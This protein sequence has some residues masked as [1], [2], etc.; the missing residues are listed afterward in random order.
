MVPQHPNLC[1]IK[2]HTPH[3]HLCNTCAP[4][5]TVSVTATKQH[6][7][8][9][10]LTMESLSTNMPSLL[11]LSPIPWL[12]VHLHCI[13]LTPCL[14][15]MV[16]QIV[17]THW[18]FTHANLTT[19]KWFTGQMVLQHPNS[20][21]SSLTTHTTGHWSV[22]KEICGVFGVYWQHRVVHSVNSYVLSVLW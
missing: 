16:L 4:Q 17:A 1:H 18:T 8:Y 15:W 22:S 10:I 19:V 9:A 20:A 11:C 14:V 21:T 13:W 6:L 2:P 12:V 7:T 5:M 3:H